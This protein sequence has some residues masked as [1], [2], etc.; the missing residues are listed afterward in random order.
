MRQMGLDREPGAAME[1]LHPMFKARP[2]M[3]RCLV[4]SRFLWTGD[5]DT[6]AQTT[7]GPASY[8]FSP[9]GA[10]TGE[11]INVRS[12]A[13]SAQKRVTIPSVRMK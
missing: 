6:P 10:A 5:F 2:D 4:S 8:C 1:L 11:P 9:D 12:T 3:L 13:R 7:D